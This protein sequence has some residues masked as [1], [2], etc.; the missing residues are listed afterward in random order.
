MMSDPAAHRPPEAPRR[1]GN[2]C[3]TPARRERLQ[4]FP[5][6]LRAGSPG[7]FVAG[8]REGKEI[9]W[10]TPEYGMPGKSGHA[11]LS[12]EILHVRFVC[13]GALAIRSR[14]QAL[15]RA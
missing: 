5:R 14:V 9:D 12:T 10:E 11:R 8:E 4:S 15:I 1:A 3:T 13:P 7:F 6:L 2:E